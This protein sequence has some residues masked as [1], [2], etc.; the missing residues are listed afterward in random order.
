MVTIAASCVWAF[1]TLRTL[2]WM[3]HVLL[4]WTWP[5][6]SCVIDSAMSNMAG[7][8]CCDLA[9]IPAPGAAL[10]LVESEVIWGL[11]WGLPKWSSSPLKHSADGVGAVGSG[12]DLCR[13]GSASEVHHPFLS[14]LPLTTRCWSLY[15]RALSLSRDDDSAALPPFGC[16]SVVQAR[17]RDDVYAFPGRREFRARVESS[18][19]SRSFKVRWVVSWWG[20]R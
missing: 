17:P 7:S 14:V 1:S 16:G 9:F 4:V 2:P 6:R 3:V 18:T 12:W 13:A 10:H 20:S 15:Q 8:L 19:A 11:R 5:S